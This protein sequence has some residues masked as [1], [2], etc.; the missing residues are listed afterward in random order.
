MD[1]STISFYNV[2]SQKFSNFY[3][4]PFIVAGKEYPT[5]EHYY[6]SKKFEET[7]KAE[8]IRLSKTIQEAHIIGTS[9]SSDFNHAKWEERKESVYYDAVFQKFSQNPELLKELLE[10]GD[11]KIVCIDED[12]FWGMRFDFE[13]DQMMGENKI[14]QI[15]M[16][17]REKLKISS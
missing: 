14:G 13:K 16:Q 5:A 10:T 2:H 11:K 15:L 8:E 17:V 3:P 6:Q 7:E 4:S 1:E 12:T 9:Y